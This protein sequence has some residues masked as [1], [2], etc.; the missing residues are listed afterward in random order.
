MMSY[1]IT[2]DKEEMDVDAIHHYL[3]RSYWAEKMP[4]GV[5]AKAIENSLCFGVL[6]EEV[7]GVEK[8]VGFARLITDSATFAYLADVYILEEHRSKGLSKQMMKQIVK[9][10]QLQGLRRI[11]LATRD[12]HGLYAQFGFTPLTDE[13]MFMQLWTPDVYQ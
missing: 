9:H 5:V 13:K 10:P 3:S 4:K 2:T 6:L 8:Q 7:S 1:R 11:M 12:A